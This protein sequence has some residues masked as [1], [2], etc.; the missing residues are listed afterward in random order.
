VGDYILFAAAFFA[1]AVTPGTDTILILSRAITNKSAAIIA[2]S[3][4]TLA[5]VLMVAIAYFG[6]SALISSFPWALTIM[7]ILGASYLIWRAVML[8]D[9]DQMREAQARKSSEFASAFAI[10]FTNPQPFAFYLSIVPLVVGT[11]SLPILLVIVIMGFA[12]VT[13]IYVSLAVLIA[14]TLENKANVVIANRILS[15][16]FLL[17]AIALVTR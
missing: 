14:R 5:K 7:K 2:A 8:W 15:A 12:I 3:G 1:A 9:T 6:L 16:I 4:I 17:L 11:T 10:G 13:G